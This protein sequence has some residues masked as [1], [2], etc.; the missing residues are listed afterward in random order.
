VVVPCGKGD[1][2]AATPMTTAHGTALAREG[3]D[4]VLGSEIQQRGEGHT[5]DPGSTCHLGLEMGTALMPQSQ[6]PIV[7]Q[8]RRSFEDRP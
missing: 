3:G 8:Q 4:H 1:L 5:M 6:S 2:A 7:A